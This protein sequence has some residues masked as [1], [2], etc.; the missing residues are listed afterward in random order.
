MSNVEL[1]T[2]YSKEKNFVISKPCH[3]NFLQIFQLDLL[4][5]DFL[6]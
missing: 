4:I 6:D 3:F 1:A 5:D 2:S